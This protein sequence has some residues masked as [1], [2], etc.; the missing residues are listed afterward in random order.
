[1]TI[2]RFLLSAAT[3]YV[4][5]LWIDSTFFPTEKVLVVEG[6][7]HNQCKWVEMT[8][9]EFGDQNDIWQAGTKSGRYAV[10]NKTGSLLKMDPISYSPGGAGE[11]AERSFTIPR[12]KSVQS[13]RPDYLMQTSPEK[14][15]TY[16]KTGVTTRWELWCR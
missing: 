12:G 16:V 7:T 3:L 6:C 4:V 8:K 1:M 10:I 13:V 2:R 11:S 14:I 15:S 9:K 5:Y